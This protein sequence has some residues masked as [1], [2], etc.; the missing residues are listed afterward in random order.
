ME[1]VLSQSTITIYDFYYNFDKL[2]ENKFHPNLYIISNEKNCLYIDFMVAWIYDGIYFK[3]NRNRKSRYEDETS[4][5][6]DIISWV[7][8]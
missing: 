3:L 4:H 7:N 6:P 2:I 1:K 5:C 8:P